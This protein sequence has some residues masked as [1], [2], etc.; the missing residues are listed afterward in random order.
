M[1]PRRSVKVGGGIAALALL[2]VA[3]PLQGASRES[4]SYARPGFRSQSF[5]SSPL[6]V[7][8]SFQSTAPAAKSSSPV[9]RSYYYYYNGKPVQLERSG[10]EL[11]VRFAAADSAAKKQEV[12]DGLSASARVSRASSLR[13]RDLSTIKVA[14]KSSAAFGRLLTGLEAKRGVEFAYSAWV[15]PKSGSRLLLTD[16]LIVRL[17]DGVASAQTRNAL[18]ARGLTVARRIAYSS[19]EYVLRLRNPKESDPLAVSR[20][21]F[22]SGLVEWAE[23]NIVQELQKDFVPDDPLFSQ[24]WHLL[25]TGQGGGTANADARLTGAWDVQ[26]GSRNITIAVIDDGVQLSHPDLAENIYTNP[27][28]IPG[29]GIDDDHNGF[30]DDVHGWNFVS[31]TN[32]LE[33]VGRSEEGDNHGTAVAGVAAARGNNGIGVSG[34]CPRCTILPV[35]IVTDGAWATYSEIVN[36]IRYAS[37]MADVLNISWGGSEPSA[38][39]Q[40]ALRYAAKN[41]RD[42]KGAVVL[43]ASGNAA[44]G[45]SRYTIAGIPPGT[46]RF[47]WVY[48]KDFDDYYPTGAD[49]AWLSW[50]RFPDG[51]LQN[52]EASA[53]LPSGWTSS[54]SGDVPWSIVNDPTHSDEGRCWSHAAK[55]G[56]ISNDQET[57]VD[58]VKTT[59]KKGDLDFLGFVSSEAGEYHFLVGGSAP[60]GFDGMYLLVDEGNDGSWDFA[61]DFFSGVPLDGLTYPAAYPE[62]I[63]VG[64]ST[65]LDCLAPY[66]QFG[67][68]L[69]LVAPSSGGDLT[70]GIVTT[71][72]TG[73]AGYSS[74][75]YF[76]GFGGTSS[77]APLAAGVAGLILSRNP[78]LTATQAREILETSADKANPGFAAYDASGHSDRY[79]YGRIDAQRAL[80]ATPLPA[81]VALSRP[82]YR[83]AEGQGALITVVRSGNTAIP[84]SVN[85]A[86]AGRTARAT[87]DFTSVFQEVSF[88]PGEQSKTITVATRDDKIHEPAELL[89]LELSKASPGAT[90]V[91]P[92]A[93]TLTIID[94]NVRF[95]KIA[96][97]RLNK[98]V[99]E[100]DQTADIA[101]NYSFA[102]R[103]GIFGYVLSRK[104]GETWKIVYTVKRVGDFDGSHELRGKMLFAGKPLPAGRY[105]LRLYA[106]TNSRRLAFSVA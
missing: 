95:G 65:S 50:V 21:L 53:D 45:F 60:L 25:N 72:R 46:Y 38:A 2:V 89:D 85:V 33:L 37:R 49:T 13:G 30:I 41:G 52:F 68:T 87:Y 63:S 44:A 8:R 61:S 86:T 51:D 17:K 70:A 79:G 106:D 75:A 31:G 84:A 29:N 5:R 58:V 81:T 12:V 92:R 78:G 48:T 14:G 24:Q 9:E 10:S 59:H 88:A 16:E 77:A 1:S 27:G 67:S 34:A 56:K 82:R 64:A 11:S 71:D 54:G 73:S 47:R 19:G 94:N 104:E 101:L 42:G 76:S 91:Q 102:R 22:H 43:A 74:G 93:A 6:A 28:E 35:K 83:V 26:R 66:S 23:P 62:A 80:S 99:F 57:F 15:D 97:A 55:A 3:T 32:N 103:S 105:L 40:S 98:T 36:A 69:D 90:I 7:R 18:A 100:R 20:E 96:S 4:V 39:F